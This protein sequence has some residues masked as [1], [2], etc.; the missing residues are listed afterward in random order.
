AIQNM[1][2]LDET[3]AKAVYKDEVV[4]D[5][6][7]TLLDSQATQGKITQTQQNIQSIAAAN[8]NLPMKYVEDLALK[9]ALPEYDKSTDIPTFLGFRMSD[10]NLIDPSTYGY[11]TG[12]SETKTTETT[13]T[14]AEGDEY[15][16][17]S[18]GDGTRGLYGELIRLDEQGDAPTGVEQGAITGISN[19]FARFTGAGG[20][21]LNPDI[22]RYKSEIDLNINKIADALRM[23]EKYST[24]ELERLEKLVESL[25]GGTF[26]S[27]TEVKSTMEAL[28][29]RIANEERRLTNILQNPKLAKGRR[30]DLQSALDAQKAAR[31]ILGV[32]LYE[33]S[34]LQGINTSDLRDSVS[35]FQ[36]D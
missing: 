33:E 16:M 34:S 14:T 35:N 7:T 20:D 27:V 25:R 30:A 18:F 28:D 22:R 8:P 1:F 2:G 21:L 12:P 15:F 3:T 32:N 36:F 23:N 11:S 9:R 19:L 6:F 17:P 10:G 29:R 24:R 4:R 26:R 5:S 13:T 31:N